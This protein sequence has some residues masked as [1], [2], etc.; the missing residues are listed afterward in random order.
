WS[1]LKYR[2]RGVQEKY[3]TINGLLEFYV[4]LGQ[5]YRHHDHLKETLDNT[6]NPL[7]IRIINAMRQDGLEPP[8]TLAFLT[9]DRAT[10]KR[11]EKLL[12]ALLGRRDLKTGPLT[13]LTAGGTGGD[14]GPGTRAKMSRSQ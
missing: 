4:G 1:P 9:P 3:S 14:L 7:K 2:S 8:V 13:N 10:A 12:I 11:G 6:H 5:H